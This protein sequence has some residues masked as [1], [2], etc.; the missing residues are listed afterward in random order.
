V[1]DV[2]A[3]SVNPTWIPLAAAAIALFGVFATLLVNGIR[4]ER[5]RRRDLHTR[6]LAAITAYGEMPY[7]IRRRAPGAELRARLC[8][9]LSLIKAE[10][11][12]CQVLLAADGDERLSDAFDD[13]YAIARKTVGKASHDAWKSPPTE[14]DSEMNMGD[15]YRS[16]EPFNVARGEFADDLRSATLPLPKR[17]SRWI[18]LKYPTLTKIPWIHSPRTPAARRT[19]APQDLV[20]SEALLPQLPDTDS[21]GSGPS[22]RQTEPGTVDP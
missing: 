19:V 17:A 3:K 4:A 10:I 8:D 6:A 22:T 2:P 16:L 15:L 12:T 11:D 14:H 13:L 7:R 1:P 9:D 21:P 5:Q 18:R 20:R